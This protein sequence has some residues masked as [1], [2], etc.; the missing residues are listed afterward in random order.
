[1]LFALYCEDIPGSLPLR[2]KARAA[3]L[4]RLKALKAEGRLVLAGPF[5]AIEANNPEAAGFTGSL[6]VAEF[7][8]LAEAEAW[9]DKDPYVTEGIFQSV[10]VKPF[11]QVLP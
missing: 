3:H 6:V 7:A 1:M 4:D 9:L 8:S 2:Q 5:P 11:K 10:T